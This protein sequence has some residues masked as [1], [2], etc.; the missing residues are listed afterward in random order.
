MLISDDVPIDPQGNSW[1]AVPQ[2]PL[3]DSHGCAVCE[4]SAGSAVTEAVKTASVM[5]CQQGD[6][7]RNVLRGFGATQLDFALQRQFQV[8]VG[9]HQ[10]LSPIALEF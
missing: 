10:R 3:Y 8:L 9:R 4:Q 1:V 6:F 2:L 5:I 7:G